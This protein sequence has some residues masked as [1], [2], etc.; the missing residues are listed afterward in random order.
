MDNN[1]LPTSTIYIVEFYR[2][3]RERKVWYFGSLAAIYIAPKQSTAV[4]YSPYGRGYIK[5][6][7]RDCGGAPL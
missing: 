5:V 2:K 7:P 1:T 3:V 4:E 6:Y